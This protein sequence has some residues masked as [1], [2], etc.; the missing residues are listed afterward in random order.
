MFRLISSNFASTGASRG[1]SKVVCVQEM[2]NK[3]DIMC[4][5]SMEYTPLRNE[6]NDGMQTPQNIK[7]LLNHLVS[8]S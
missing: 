4:L 3:D 8:N 6:L 2:S 5:Q 7:S 1:V